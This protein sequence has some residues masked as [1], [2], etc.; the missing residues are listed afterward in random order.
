V[1][2]KFLSTLSLT[3]G[4]GLAKQI[5]V[6]TTAIAVMIVFFMTKRFNDY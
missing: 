6:N 1:A 2:L 3:A 5:T 4:N